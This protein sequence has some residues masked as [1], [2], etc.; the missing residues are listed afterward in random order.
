MLPRETILQTDEGPPVCLLTPCCHRAIIRIL[1][2]D[3]PTNQL[4]SPVPELAKLGSTQSVVD[5]NTS[6]DTRQRLCGMIDPNEYRQRAFVSRPDGCQIVHGDA[7]TVLASLPSDTYRCCVTS[8]PYWGLR[9]YGT[10]GQIGS[11]PSVDEYV[12]TLVQVFREVRRVLTPDGTL[13]LNLGDS[14]TSGNRAWRDSDRKNPARAMHYRPPT[15]KGL[16]PK[17]LVG[18]P[19]RVAFA[20]QADG[21]FLRSDIIWHKP[22]CQPESVKDRPTRAHEYIFL[23]SASEKY[24]YDYDAI[25]EPGTNP[26]VCRNRRTVWTVPTQPYAEAHFATFPPELIEP[27]V[28][29]G[30]AAGDQVLDPFFGSGTLG[31]VCLAKGRRFT[32]IEISEEYVA[33]AKRRLKWED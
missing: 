24:Y 29:A 19:W 21:W 12:D 30:S 32:G 10:L 11:E 7:Q 3:T 4:P 6:I 15:P 8:P 18:V 22:N 31:E 25:K 9:D 13:W 23:L 14:Y 17:D 28:L 5:S 16:K 1:I 33:L 2:V 26:A 27:C 20:L